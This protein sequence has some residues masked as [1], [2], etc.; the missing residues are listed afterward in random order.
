MTRNS[1]TDKH[2][3]KRWKV[4]KQYLKEERTFKKSS[5]DIYQ[6]LTITILA[7]LF[8]LIMGMAI[9]SR[10][11]SNN[12]N[13]Y[14]DA[15]NKFLNEYMSIK[16]DYYE[17]LD[18]NKTM[19]TALEAI[20]NSLDDYSKVVDD[21][22]SNSLSTKLQGSYQ[23]FGVEIA[24]DN[25]NDIVIA[26]II[27]DS[28]AEKAKL[29]PLD[30]IKKLDDKVISN[31]STT[32]F[33]KIVKESDKAKFNLTIIRD[34]QEMV[35]EIERKVVTLQSIATD[36]YEKNNKKVGYIYVNVFAYNTDKQF[37]TALTELENK[38]IDSLIVDLRYNTGGHLTAVENM[39]SEFLD[40]NHIMYQIQ[41]KT[42]VEKHYSTSNTKRKYKV[43][44]LVNGYSASASEMF[45]AAMQEEY[46]ATIIGTTTFGKGTVQE[47]Q[48][49][50]S[51]DI[52]Y[53]LTT[54]K[55]LTPKGKWINKVGVE[56]NISVELK[57][58]DQD[59]FTDADD[60]QLQTAINELTK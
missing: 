39:I 11:M 18:D 17:D 27:K 47:V 8:S 31:M 43:A 20:L 48:D 3:T 4:E 40:K 14:S 41:T 35:I 23:G 32:D 55:W 2:I 33:I 29:Q 30:I 10:S 52:Q 22:L 24:N 53:K 16:D 19:K 51:T 38:G 12:S 5:F 1:D 58:D 13:N 28:P 25:N 46:G 15:I 37:K 50:T 36:V 54:K 21:S 26:S 49:S 42:D 44:V 59:S 7:S 34:G 6:V 57:I 56:P 45:A 60:N 9:S